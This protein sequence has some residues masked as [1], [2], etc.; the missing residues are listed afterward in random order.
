MS[1]YSLNVILLSSNSLKNHKKSL[2][3]KKAIW[4][5]KYVI[6]IIVRTSFL[7]GFFLPSFHDNPRTL[8]GINKKLSIDS[9]NRYTQQ[10]KFNSENGCTH[11]TKAQDINAELKMWKLLWS[12]FLFIS[13]SLFPHTKFVFRAYFK[14][15]MNM[16]TQNRRAKGV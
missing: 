5:R 10:N 7:F 6:F 8:F 12:I 16:L 14:A 11:I 15:Q 1:D 9:A 4:S 13:F 2:V 3:Q